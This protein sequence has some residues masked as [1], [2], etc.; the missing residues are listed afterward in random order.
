MKLLDVLCEP[1]D[2]QNLVPLRALALALTT[3]TGYPVHT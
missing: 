3:A 2:F 1:R